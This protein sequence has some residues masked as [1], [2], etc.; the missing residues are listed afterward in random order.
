M[1]GFLMGLVVVAIAQAPA[2]P[3]AV[4]VPDF[5]TSIDYLA[6]LKNEVVRRQP[7]SDNAA[8]LYRAAFPDFG[9]SESGQYNV[10]FAGFLSN[11]GDGKRH[12]GSPWDPADHP[13]WE[14]SWTA[15]RDI[16]GKIRTAAEKP[17]C[18]TTPIERGPV[19]NGAGG[20]LRA[21][22]SDGGAYRAFAKGL[23]ENAL[24]APG[25]KIDGREFNANCRATLL[26]AR[27]VQR[28]PLLMFQL[29][30]INIRSMAYR[31]LRAALADGALTPAERTA[32][33]KML[34]EVDTPIP[35]FS[36]WMRG[37]EATSFDLVQLVMEKS[38]S[39]EDLDSLRAEMKKRGISDIDPR[40]CAALVQEY[41]A[42]IGKLGDRPYHAATI[43]EMDN[44][45]EQ[46]VSKVPVAELLLSP[47]ARAYNLRNRTVAERRATRLLYEIFIF[48]DKNGRWPNALSDLPGDL[49][50]QVG[51]DPWSG[52]PFLYK[53]MDGKPQLYSAGLNALDDGGIHDP[54][55]G[56]RIAAS[57]YIF[58]PPQSE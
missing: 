6:W 7:E 55:W 49:L 34:A 16:E 56:D 30:E 52:K 25:G 28:S 1:N 32:T 51:I 9:K 15:T 5:K 33:A 41:T 53:L 21:F 46:A 11:P 38:A 36:F 22:F 18:W 3:S 14:Q 37:E 47:L 29:I 45:K 54:K 2:A 50:K 39:G 40:Q 26:I 48:H 12:D 20:L 23:M 43:Q 44:Q 27:Q 24:R 57:D 10:P 42:A 58:W 8:P 31:G 17:Y 19:V 13:D 35:S 4:P